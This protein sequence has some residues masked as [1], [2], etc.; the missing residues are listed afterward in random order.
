[1]LFG[2]PYTKKNLLKQKSLRFYKR[3]P[4]TA[5]TA[6]KTSLENKYFG[7]G[8]DYR[9]FLASFNVNSASCKGSG[10]S[11]VEINIENEK[12]FVECSRCR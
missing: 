7:N 1:M 6:T 9:F 3:E 5:V 4:A 2:E 11:V 12:F 10:R 8:C